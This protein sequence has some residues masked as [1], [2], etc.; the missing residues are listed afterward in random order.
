MAALGRWIILQQF[1]ARE[2]I[3]VKYVS[4][5]HELPKREFEYKDLVVI[6]HSLKKLQDNLK[7]LSDSL[8]DVITEVDTITGQKWREMY[9]VETTGDNGEPGEAD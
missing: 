3:P 1:D 4:T 8:R 9:H 7:L 6:L 5:T 2:D